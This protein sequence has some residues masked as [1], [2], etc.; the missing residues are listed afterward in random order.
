MGRLGRKACIGIVVVVLVALATLMGTGI[1]NTRRTITVGFMYDNDESTPYSYSFYLAQEELQAT[2]GKQVRVIMQGNVPED[3][4]RT[5]V[6]KLAN[7]GCDIIFTNGYGDVR[8]MAAEYPDIEFC[9]VSNDA[10]PASDALSNYHTFKGEAYQARYASGVV[11]GLKLQQMIDKGI[12]DPT[13]AK[14]GFVAAYPFT[15]VIS[16]FTAFLLGVRSVVPTATMQVKYTD[17]W[18]SYTLEK[19]CASELLDEGCV[20]ISQHSDTVGPAI[21]CEECYAHEAYH[22]GYNIDMTDVAPN[23][24]LTSARI[25]WTPYVVGAVQAVMDGTPIEDTV[26]GKVHP[27]NDMSA[28]FEQG[29]VELTPLNAKLL[30]KDAQAV[31]NQA[32][33]DLASGQTEVF[34]GDYHG[35]NPAD[36]SD[37]IDLADGFVENADSSIPSFCYLLDDVVSVED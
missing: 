11:V 26:D 13:E 24:S 9:Q 2:F 35:V 23:T 25:N 1:P 17:V 37:V 12:I 36:A 27:C 28:G 5:P 33:S 8:S 3:D 15:E 19:E 4:V 22:V 14:T 10:Y 18:G 21:A 20:I 34:C 29:W 7:Q 31:V 16:G 32:I 6:T 30:P